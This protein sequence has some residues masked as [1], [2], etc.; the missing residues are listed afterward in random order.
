MSVFRRLAL[1]SSMVLSSN[2]ISQHWFQFAMA[3]L[4]VTRSPMQN[5]EYEFGSS[6]LSLLSWT[7]SFNNEHCTM[8]LLVHARH[9]RLAAVFLF[10]DTHMFIRPKSHNVVQ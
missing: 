6:M 8:N 1:L 9:D 7:Q 10:W 3:A 4:S 5:A 2:P